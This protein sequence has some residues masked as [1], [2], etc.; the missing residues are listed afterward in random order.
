MNMNLRI[1]FGIVVAS[2]VIMPGL[3]ASSNAS[4]LS[5]A[6][7]YADCKAAFA[8][9]Y[10][11]YASS[12]GGNLSVIGKDG[13]AFGSDASEL[14]SIA[15]SGN[16][17]AFYLYL[18]NK[19]DPEL[20]SLSYNITSSVRLSGI[21][22][23]D[24]AKLRAYYNT[25]LA[26]YDACA[27]NATESFGTRILLR[28]NESISEML[29][30]AS[31]LSSKGINTTNLTA[32]VQGAKTEIITPLASG[33]ASAKNLSEAKAVV[34]E[35]CLFNGCDNGTNMHLAAR[36][37]LKK[38]KLE[39]AY[40]ESKSNS[41]SSNTGF[42]E[43][44]SNLTFASQVLASVGTSAYSGNQSAEIWSSLNRA[45]ARMRF[46][47]T[48]E[49]AE[50]KIQEIEQNLHAYYGISE[51]LAARGLNTTQINYTL[52]S[53]ESEVIGPLSAMVNASANASQM[54]SAFESYC[55][56]NGCPDG[57]NFHIDARLESEALNATFARYVSRAN[58]SAIN[59]S[60]IASFHNYYSAAES[61]IADAGTS[62][63]Q[64]NESEAISAYLKN[65]SDYLIKIQR[66]H[67]GR[68]IHSN[69]SATAVQHENES[70]S[71]TGS[72]SSVGPSAVTT[73]GGSQSTE[74]QNTSVSSNSNVEVN[75]SAVGIRGST[76]I[77]V[78]GGA[79]SS[80]RNGS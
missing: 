57:M 34:S 76:S 32:L 45:S 77:T 27:A 49:A 19:F 13:A 50:A 36:F 31:S 12:L 14:G 46:G 65:A 61:D 67:E 73:K 63:I 8:T 55:I 24:M 35:Y 54:R 22:S 60:L 28:Y 29:G 51:S 47:E 21:N 33:L 23:T 16:S 44:E 59:Q 75:A 6:Y 7:A 30:T 43:A 25:S 20:N 72:A 17:S 79:K 64:A 68:H 78:D 70:A 71:A 41:S 39:L 5:S 58:A 74:E 26:A 11:S 80:A 53:A 2:A 48:R 56:S 52:A 1:L 9:G 40:L 18:H 66:E 69:E 42:S 15:S 10:A 3:M 62:Q 37:T 4:V 38:L